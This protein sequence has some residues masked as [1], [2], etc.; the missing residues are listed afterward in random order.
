MSKDS[1][2]PVAPDVNNSPLLLLKA[3]LNDLPSDSVILLRPVPQ[4]F[5][6]LRDD[7]DLLLTES[8]RD[9]LLEAAYRLAVA[10]HL[11]FR[12]EQNRNEKVRLT[13]WNLDATRSIA[14]DLWSGIAQLGGWRK[15]V[16]ISAEDLVHYKSRDLTSHNHEIDGEVL[17]SWPAVSRLQPRL[18]FCLYVLHLASKRKRIDAP[19]VT[20]RLHQMQ[21]RMAETEEGVPDW[22]RACVT[23]A[24]KQRKLTHTGWL[25]ALCWLGQLDVADRKLQFASRPR[26]R[27]RR[28]AAAARN[29]FNR[30][31]PWIAFCGCDGVG[32]STLLQRITRNTPDLTSFAAK[33]FYR[34]SL[35]YQIAGGLWR[36]SVGWSRCDLDDSIPVLLT[37]RGAVAAAV[38]RSLSRITMR[39]RPA[40]LLDRSLADPLIRF[41]KT[42]RPEPVRKDGGLSR[43][44]SSTPTVLMVADHS[45]LSRR[46]QEMTPSGGQRYQHLLFRRALDS[47]ACDVIC[48]ANSLPLDRASAAL[49]K[50][51]GTA[52]IDSAKP[53]AVEQRTRPAS[54]PADVRRAA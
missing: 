47:H 11:H 51:I 16:L 38:Q 31:K 37:L 30:S 10:G 35:T 6:E 3:V 18:E 19:A 40:M 43:F 29:W 2:Q 48:F 17:E 24:A 5:C 53:P 32:K 33:K 12:V 25:K 26:Q 45:S 15:H 44:L 21:N 49:R 41:R 36:R 52:W 39:R 54:D 42:D 7:I 13:I 28:L 9:M 34:R 46:K 1:T 27:R 22:F 20:D 8:T 4:S 23:P 14:V 50:C